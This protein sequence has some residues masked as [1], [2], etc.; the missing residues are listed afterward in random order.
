VGQGTRQPGK[1]KKGA[2]GWG[3]A[4]AGD[5]HVALCT[6]GCIFA[7]NSKAGRRKF[8][9][10]N[11]ALHSPSQEDRPVTETHKNKTGSVG[12]GHPTPCKRATHSCEGWVL[13][14]APE[15]L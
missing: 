14:P 7:G 9:Y 11:I 12:Q 3:G 4:L 1:A 6:G 5:S 10:V 13:D 8:A 2:A 15:G